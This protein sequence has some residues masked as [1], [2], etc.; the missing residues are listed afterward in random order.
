[1]NATD[2]VNQANAW[3]RLWSRLSPPNR[4][5]EDTALPKAAV[6]PSVPPRGKRVLIVDDDEVV[7]K[8]T[9]LKL[10]AHGYDVLTAMDG[11]QTIETVRKQKPD[12]ILLDL[13]FP[14]DVAHGGCVAW[15]GFL[16]MSWLRRLESARD[17]PVIVITGG[18]AEKFEARSLR[19][20]AR[21]FFHKPINHESLLAV[22]D[23]AVGQ[24]NDSRQTSD[25]L[26]FQI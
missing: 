24:T 5:G 11:A 6:K 7:L 8:T 3:K 16:I 21:A 4:S 20:G 23:E 2:T 19:S 15:D 26:N 1:M 18:D 14:P 10:K 25:N 13:S 22:V 12:A 9:A 17:I